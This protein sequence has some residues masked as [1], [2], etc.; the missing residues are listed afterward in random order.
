MSHEFR[1]STELLKED[2][3]DSSIKKLEFTPIFVLTW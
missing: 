3:T 2:L 1:N